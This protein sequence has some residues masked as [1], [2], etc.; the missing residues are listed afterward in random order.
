M[1]CDHENPENEILCVHCGLPIGR[2]LTEDLTTS[3]VKNGVTRTLDENA[4]LSAFPRWGTARLGM[5]RKLLFHVRSYDQPLVVNLT[6]KLVIGRFDT[7]TGEVPDVNLEEF[8]AQKMGVSRRHAAI[9]VEDDGLKVM[10]LGSANSTYING[11]KL[12]AHQ[13]RILRDGDELRLGNLVI[14][15]N[16]A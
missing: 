1:H 12:F 6:E 2:N 7:E 10:D 11:Q 14:R 8:D 13:T 16:F 5:E 9:L 3:A 4:Q 15:I